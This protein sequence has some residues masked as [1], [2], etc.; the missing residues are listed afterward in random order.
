MAGVN[1]GLAQTVLAV[2]CHGVAGDRT[3][4]AGRTDDLDNIAVVCCS[5]RFAFRQAD[6]LPDDLPLFVD[7][8]AELRS[9]SGNQLECDLVLALFQFACKSQSG[10][11]LQNRMFDLDYICVCVPQNS[12]PP[13]I[14]IFASVIH[15]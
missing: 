15:E 14:L 12:F 13:L 3:V 2:L 10:N 6:T 5:R 7:T 9:R 1:A 4:L 11:F 8:A